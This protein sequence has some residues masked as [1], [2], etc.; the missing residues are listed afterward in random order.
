MDDEIVSKERLDS[1]TCRIKSEG[2]MPPEEYYSVVH[3]WRMLSTR[4]SNP[5]PFMSYE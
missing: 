3:E 1:R 4:L 5:R 2:D